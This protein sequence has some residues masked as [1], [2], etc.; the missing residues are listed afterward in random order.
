MS[1]L[2]CRVSEEGR[3]RGCLE[4][5]WRCAADSA[6]APNCPFCPQVAMRLKL[7][8]L[9]GR[10]DEKGPPSRPWEGALCLD[11]KGEVALAGHEVS[12]GGGEAR[13]NGGTTRTRTSAAQPQ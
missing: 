13:R 5:N 8:P 3:G 10:G 6:A 4:A 12:G 9:W 2:E 11:G 7:S 1:P